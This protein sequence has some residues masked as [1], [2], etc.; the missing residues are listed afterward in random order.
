MNHDSALNNSER[1]YMPLKN[2]EKAPDNVLLM[3][4]IELFDIQTVCKQMTHATLNYS[5]YN[6]LII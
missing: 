5:K 3:G 4:Q 2:Q 1:V 6:W